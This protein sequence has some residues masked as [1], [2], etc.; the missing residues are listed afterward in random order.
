MFKS[1]TCTSA[2][3]VA[4]VAPGCLAAEATT[5]TYRNSGAASATANTTQVDQYGLSTSEQEL[6][7][8]WGIN[9]E[10]MRRAKLLLAGPRGTFSQPNLSPIEAL[11][12]H[13]R[14]QQE[15][16]K[17]ATAFAKALHDDTE[18]VLAWSQ[19]VELARRGAYGVEK[20]V[21]FS[22]ITERPSIDPAIAAAAK[23]PR[24]A[25]TPTKR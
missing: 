21:D 20:V 12:I 17:Y 2:L 23:V 5:T 4:F 6:A 19:A 3:F 24:S 7:R 8:V 18:R 25:I 1:L 11:G 9:G 10:E 22:R 15:R 16:Q 14:T 13:A